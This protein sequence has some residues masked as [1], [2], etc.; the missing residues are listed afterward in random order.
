MEGTEAAATL[1]L[2]ISTTSAHLSLDHLET[3]MAGMGAKLQSL[4]T[5]GGVA[6]SQNANK[7]SVELQASFDK[8]MKAATDGYARQIAEMQATIAAL[9]SKGVAAA[10]G[11]GVRLASG[12]GS[13]ANNLVLSDE[14]LGRFHARMKAAGLESVKAL[15][16]GFTS[17]N[18]TKSNQVVAAFAKNTE[19]SLQSVIRMSKDAQ[20]SLRAYGPQ[21]AADT[22][23]GFVVSGDAESRARIALSNLAYAKQQT[24][25]AIKLGTIQKLNESGAESAALKANLALRKAEVEVEKQK[26]ALQ[27]LNESGAESAAL[28]A[29]LAVLK[30]QTKELEAQAKWLSLTEKQRASAVATAARAVY[31]TGGSVQHQSTLPGVAGSQQALAAAQAAGSIAAAETALN[32]L[33]SSHRTLAPAIASSTAGQINW[34]HAAKEGHTVVR[35]LAGSLGSLWVTYGQLAP[36]LAGAALGGAFIHAAK[37]GSEFVYQLTF[38]KALSEETSAAVDLLSN[39][40]LALGKNSL[41]GPSEI[42]DGYRVLA[43]AG[44]NVTDSIAAMPQVLHLVTVGEMEMEAAAVTL[45]GVIN[46]FGLSISSVEHVGD[47]FAKAGAVSQTSVLDMT[48]AMKA[49]SV[50]G[51]QYGASMEDTAT[52]LTL[53]AKVNIRGTAAGTAFRNMLK[54]LYAPVQG[55]EKIFKKL[56]VDAQDAVGNIRPFADVI[57]ELK[58]KLEVFNK[59]DQVKILQKLF[60]ER[61]AKEAIAMM[62]LTKDKWVELRDSI[63]NSEGFMDGVAKELEDTV[64]G[65]WLKAVNTMKSTFISAFTEMEPAFK[66]LADSLNGLFNDKEFVDGLKQTVGVMLTLTKAAIDMAPVLIKL[67]EA[68]LILKAAT[69]STAVWNAASLAVTGFGGALAVVSGAMG[70]V[71]AGATVARTA[72]GFLP[73]AF[74]AL[75]SP[76]GLVVG[77]LAAAGTAF[78]L[79]RDRTGEAMDAGLL[80]VQNFGTEAKKILDDLA[81]TL[82]TTSTAVNQT[83]VSAAQTA[84]AAQNSNVD[85]LAKTYLEKYGKGTNAVGTGATVAAAQAY[86]QKQRDEYRGGFLQKLEMNSDKASAAQALVDAQSEARKLQQQFYPLQAEVEQKRIEEENLAAVKAAENAKPKTGNVADILGSDSAGSAA[87]KRGEQKDFRTIQNDNLASALKR[88]QILL[89]TQLTGV[90]ID[91]AAQTISAAVAQERKNAASKVELETEGKIIARYLK[92]AQA[93]GDKVQVSKIENDL[94]ENDLKLKRLQEQAELDLTKVRTADSNAI[95]NTRLAS[96]RYVEDLQFEIEMI[97]KTTAEVAKLRIER[98]AARATENLGVLVSRNQINDGP[99]DALRAEIEAKRDAQ[100]ADAAYQESWVGGWSRARDAWL[101]DATSAAKQAQSA[102]EIMSSSMEDALDEFLTTGKIN[103]A[104]FAKSII[105]E[106]AKIEARALMAKASTSVGGG[107]GILGFLGGL[108]GGGGS[109]TSSTSVLSALGV[110]NSTPYANGGVFSGAPSLHAYAN[111]VRST[112]TTFA[113]QNLHGFANG[114]VFAEAGTEAVMPIMQSELGRDAQ[115]RLGIKRGAQGDTINVTVHVNGNQSAPD[116]RRSAAQGA[117]EGLAA[118]RGAQRYA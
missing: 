18:F 72:L 7:I 59:G 27:K 48:Q 91:L 2:E 73:A 52:A 37:A 21:T 76:V 43:Q 61:G 113:Y 29:N 89:G 35:G 67:A 94:A 85:D 44:L 22:F 95:E 88:E 107:D 101:K 80:K 104:D 82:G 87:S 17:S 40:T 1:S 10:K 51:E 30:A 58:E 75:L 6:A 57:F 46:A 69:I 93:T 105:L 23:G 54:E 41:Q 108:F 14:Q 55:S 96:G 81:R 114:A 36:L 8:Q 109:N 111:T 79:F 28:K 77:G 99:A 78:L 62:A 16:A 26:A 49:A 9:E 19:A 15:E 65:R 38:V 3:R 110:A 11:L 32:G 84:V 53:L 34:N 98:E 42:A 20:Q 60:G 116:V 74:T 56:G 63:S 100:L 112:P 68:W 31:G 83:R 71:V 115:G 25:E 47:V 86:L 39:S 45:V 4:L 64:R 90:E 118:F 24:E 5:A 106:M 12:A 103:F 97:G 70:P 66:D 13:L 92:Q 33:T 117:R 50:V 102:F